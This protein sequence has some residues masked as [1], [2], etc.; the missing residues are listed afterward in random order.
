MRA[1]LLSAELRNGGEEVFCEFEITNGDFSETRGATLSAEDFLKYKLA[2]GE[3]D[4]GLLDAI[5]RDAEVYAAFK[6]GLYLLGYGASS[7]KNI[8]YKLKTKG[9]GE[10]A[11]A[12]A[13]KML[14]K[15]GFIDEARDAARLAEICTAKLCGK[16]KIAA[17]LFEKGYGQEIVASVIAGLDEEEMTENCACLIAKKY[18]GIPADRAERE[19]MFAFLMRYGYTGDTIKSAISL[20]K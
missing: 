16:K 3:I 13:A 15:K 17:H 20:L 7:R 14:C 1:F 9:F 5:F 11:A 12:A 4:A 6:K 8:S 19:K 10:S 2:E 18:G